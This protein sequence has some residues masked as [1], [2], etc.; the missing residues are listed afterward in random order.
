MHVWMMSKLLYQNKNKNKIKYM[1]TIYGDIYKPKFNLDHY[2]N[3]VVIPVLSQVMLDPLCC[4][5]RLLPSP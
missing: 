1:S 5:H 2:T 4:D 3:L